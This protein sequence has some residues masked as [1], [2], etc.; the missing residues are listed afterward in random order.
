MVES[1]ANSGWEVLVWPI[2]LMFLVILQKLTP[3]IISV[4]VMLT[5]GAKREESRL[6]SEILSCKKQLN[7]MSMTG[8]YVK[9]VK[10][11]REIIKLEQ[12]LKP[13]IDERKESKGYAKTALNVAFYILL[14]L[15]FAITMYNCYSKAIVPELK[16]E[17][18]YPIG[19]FIG[20]PTGASTCI[21]VPFFLLMLRTFVN[22]VTS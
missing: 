9:Y 16:D 21:G 20:L 4:V 15:L 2:W 5:H 14:G 12:K 19:Y 10:L 1:I 7:Q 13:Y 11:Q 3:T 17:W 6:A 8:E 18:L 22:S